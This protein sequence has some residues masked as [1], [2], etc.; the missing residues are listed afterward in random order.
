MTR[1]ASDDSEATAP[2]TAR[3]RWSTGVEIG[4]HPGQGHHDDLDP[5]HDLPGG[6]WRGVDGGD[7]PESRD[8]EHAVGGPLDPTEGAGDP[9]A[10]SPS[11]R[12][13]RDRPW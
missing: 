10:P 11:R 8:H 4:R 3:P 13:A 5:Q 2:H 1:A 9:G 6:G 7:V 12:R